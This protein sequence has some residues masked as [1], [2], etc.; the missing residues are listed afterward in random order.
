MKSL[1]LACNQ[2]RS[3]SLRGRHHHHG[4]GPKTWGTIQGQIFDGD[5]SES[6]AAH[7][8]GSQN[9]SYTTPHWPVIALVSLVCRRASL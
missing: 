4:L 1:A 9:Y 5:A 3:I 8:G 6:F 7:H 2:D